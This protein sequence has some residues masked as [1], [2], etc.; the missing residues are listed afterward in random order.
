MKR[1]T[2]VINFST[3]AM[4]AAVLGIGN[5]V[6]FN[7]GGTID[8]YL[9]KSETNYD[10]DE[11]KNAMSQGKDL[12]VE[13]S[14]NGSVLLKNSNNCLPLSSPNINIFGW[15][16]SDN[17]FLYQG[18]GSSQGGYDTD[19]VSLYQ[20]FRNAG[21]NVNESLCSAYNSLSYRREGAS[22][23]VISS[24]SITVCMSQRKTSTP[25]V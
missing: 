10:T 7:Y 3:I 2:A 15:G 18:G 9:S 11:V 14:E 21:F 22:D 12:A 6:A 1:T 4:L 17:G 23:S 25:T 24:L 5:A 20:G 13:I 19:K 16:G 8:L